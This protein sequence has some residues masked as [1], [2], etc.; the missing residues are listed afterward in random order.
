[1][2]DAVKVTGLDDLVKAL[3]G[4]MF[5]DVNRELRQHA[6]TIAADLMP[7]AAAAVRRGGAPQADAMAKTFRVHSDRVPVFAMGKTNPRFG[8]GFAH[9]GESG[10]QRKRRRGSLAHGVVYGPKGG[11]RKHGGEN[12]YRT[13][14]DSSGGPLGASLDGGRTF[15]HALEVYLRVY[16]GVLR[17]HGFETK[18]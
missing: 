15:K 2:S 3:K 14:R 5:R 6:R 8:G 10:A 18:G 17:G 11:H 1:M 12:F 16:L 7:D 9:K 4:P 13:G